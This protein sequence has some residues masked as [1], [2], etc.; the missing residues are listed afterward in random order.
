MIAEMNLHAAS[1]VHEALR[2]IRVSTRNKLKSFTDKRPSK[3]AWWKFIS[4]FWFEHEA[5][6]VPVEEDHSA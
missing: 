1:L 4:I 2:A 3:S 6:P 5:E